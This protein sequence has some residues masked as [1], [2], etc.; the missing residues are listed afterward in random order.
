LIK[1]LE[2]LV[3]GIGSLMNDGVVIGKL[4][5]YVLALEELL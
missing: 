1:L 2:K 3:G 4:H 5:W